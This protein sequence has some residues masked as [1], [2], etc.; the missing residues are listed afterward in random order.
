MAER[1]LRR[2]LGLF[3]VGAVGVLSVLVL[4]FG[5]TPTL[6]AN[7]ATYTVLFPE[8]PGI[9]PGT[10]VRKSGVRIG[11]VTTL[12]LDEAT[13]QV[14]VNVEVDP[15]HAPRTGE[16]PV[17]TRGFLSGDTALDF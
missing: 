5:G 1:A 17:I 6:F 7:R 3:V 14:R 8:A 12:D 9:T 2:R 13:G 10:P 4:L 15:K 16:E 11:E